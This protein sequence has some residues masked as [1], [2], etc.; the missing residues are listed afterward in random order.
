[1]ELPEIFMKY[2]FWIQ[3]RKCKHSI[4]GIVLFNLVTCDDRVSQDIIG[5]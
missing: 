4:A 1:M 5:Q 3:Y 2:N